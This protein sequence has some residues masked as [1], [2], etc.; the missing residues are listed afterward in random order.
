MS[1]AWKVF[2]YTWK[3]MQHIHFSWAEVCQWRTQSVHVCGSYP[4]WARII[5]T[6]RAK[7][8]SLAILDL[9]SQL[10]QTGGCYSSPE[11]FRRLNQQQPWMLRRN[12]RVWNVQFR[13]TLVT[14]LPKERR[15]K[16]KASPRNVL[17][18]RLTILVANILLL[19]IYL[20]QTDRW[21]SWPEHHEFK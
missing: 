5:K 15:Q 10:S 6:F 11:L 17:Q 1:N 12:D 9:V 16:T 13:T 18:Q 21:L 14:C 4:Y 2:F 7:N 3:Q 20:P 8:C 19:L